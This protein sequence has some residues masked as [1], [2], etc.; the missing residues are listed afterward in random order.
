MPPTRRP[1][2]LVQFISPPPLGGRD[3]PSQT[4]I[5]AIRTATCDYAALAYTYAHPTT[6]HLGILYGTYILEH[7]H[8]AKPGRA[9][10]FQ[11]LCALHTTHAV[12][13]R[14]TP[15]ALTPLAP[16]RALHAPLHALHTH[17]IQNKLQQHALALFTQHA[18][19]P[20]YAITPRVA[21]RAAR[22]LLQ[23]TRAGTCG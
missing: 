16:S 21:T 22:H 1:A 7:G 2:F 13:A 17:A 12:R 20:H 19:A 14:W 5:P 8:T 3:A 23:H 18:P 6:H 15:T 11:V 10:F 9:A 4:F